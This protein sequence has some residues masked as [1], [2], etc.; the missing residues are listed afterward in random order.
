[1]SPFRNKS[2]KFRA[3]LSL[4]FYL[5]ILFYAFA[6]IATFT[7][8]IALS[9]HYQL[10]AVFGSLSFGVLIF[11]PFQPV[12]V[13]LSLFFRRKPANVPASISSTSGSCQGVVE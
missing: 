5:F 2:L 6:G 12:P 11:W 13:L 9:G 10:A 1:M 4:A 7:A 8:I 3:G